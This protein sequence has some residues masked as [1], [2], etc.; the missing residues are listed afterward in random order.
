MDIF[1]YN[2]RG[3]ENSAEIWTKMYRLGSFLGKCISFTN[4]ES[5]LEVKPN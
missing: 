5:K 3:A 1:V 2:K 4:V